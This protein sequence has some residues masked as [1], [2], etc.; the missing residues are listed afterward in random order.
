[1]NKTYILLII[2][3]AVWGISWVNA[4]IITQYAKADELVLL[5]YVLSMVA[6]FII[7]IVLRKSLK[8]DI[9]NSILALFGG[10]LLF[11]H[12]IFFLK[13]L[14]L[15]TASLGGALTTTWIPIFTFIFLVV[16]FKKEVFKKDIFAL[17]IGF[18]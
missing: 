15:G 18:V 17:F 5:R 1:M 11:A 14:E 7:L 4:K 13:G 10:A 2:C 9:K 6:L 3:M 16:F 12:S 8:I